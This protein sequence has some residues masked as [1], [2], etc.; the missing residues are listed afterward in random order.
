[1]NLKFLCVTKTSAAVSVTRQPGEWENGLM[2]QA[3]M[4]GRRS[5]DS[6][7]ERTGLMNHHRAA[8]R[9]PAVTPGQVSSYT[10]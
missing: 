7:R 10:G 6:H 3:E 5:R 4:M 2:N 9:G 8:R 1:M